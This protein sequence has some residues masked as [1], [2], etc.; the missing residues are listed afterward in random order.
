MDPPH[1]AKLCEL[2]QRA[3]VMPVREATQALR[4]EPDSVYVIPPNAELSVVGGTLHLAPRR[5]RAACGCRSTCC[6]M[7]GLESADRLPAW[8]AHIAANRFIDHY[9]SRRPTEELPEDLVAAKADDDPVVTLAP[10]L[11]AMIERLPATYREAVRLSDLEEVP[12]REVARRLGIS[13]SGSKSRVQ[14]GRAL[15]RQLVEACCVDTCWNICA[16]QLSVQ[17]ALDRAHRHGGSCAHLQLAQQRQVMRKRW[18]LAARHLGAVVPAAQHHCVLGVRQRCKAQVL[19][20]FQHAA[21][22]TQRVH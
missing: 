9:R 19:V 3:T 16:F 17:A 12:Q 14:R 15:L 7:H 8:L 18:R 11:P 13:L 5:S 4:I 22:R 1:K 10:C 21:L 2:L 20:A 6:S